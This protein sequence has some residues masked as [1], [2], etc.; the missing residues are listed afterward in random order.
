MY[1]NFLPW[2]L[3][4]HKKLDPKDQ[5]DSG[6]LF[7]ESM[8]I[9]LPGPN[10]TLAQSRPMGCTLGLMVSILPL[11]QRQSS[12]SGQIK[13]P[14]SLQALVEALPSLFHLACMEEAPPRIILQRCYLPRSSCGDGWS[15]LH[16][17]RRQSF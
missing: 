14:D 17:A 11:T 3:T 13:T 12:L 2:F 5:G 4:T 15:C 7:C 16:D 10:S 9:E 1:P 8:V 6:C